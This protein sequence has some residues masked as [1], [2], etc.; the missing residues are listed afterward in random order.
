MPA[1]DGVG[2][3]KEAAKTDPD[4]GK[5]FLFFTGALSQERSSFLL[6]KGISCILKPSPLRVIK[7][8]VEKIL[9][10]RILESPPLGR[11]GTGSGRD[12]PQAI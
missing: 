11:N 7:E 12:V 9:E 5:R 10:S 6:E 1:L 3:Y 4:I 8:K 2:F